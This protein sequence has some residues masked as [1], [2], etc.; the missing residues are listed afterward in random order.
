MPCSKNCAGFTSKSS[1]HNRFLLI[2]NITACQAL[3]ELLCLHTSLNPLAAS[4]ERHDYYHHFTAKKTEIRE[5]WEAAGSHTLVSRWEE[6][7]KALDC[8]A[9]DFDRSPVHPDM[10]PPPPC[11]PCSLLQR[12]A[13]LKSCW[14]T[15]PS[16]E[17]VQEIILK[18]LFGQMCSMANIQNSH[19][20]GLLKKL[21]HFL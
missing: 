2:P 1:G 14:N 7:W 21:L 19:V 17:Q 13:V 8:W 6:G 12:N 9:P 5:I 3:D 18:L 10:W 16:F 4:W 15:S 20:L 11:H